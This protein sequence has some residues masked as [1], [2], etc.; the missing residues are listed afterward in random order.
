MNILIIN[1]PSLNLLGKREPEIYGTMSYG[2]L[3]KNL[4]TYCE[5]RHIDVDIKQTNL[6]GIMIDMLHYASHMGF[7][8]VV[9]NAAAFTHYSYAIYDAIKAIEVPVYEVHLSDPDTRDETFRHTSVIR[10]AC[11]ATFK[12]EGIMSYKKAIDAIVDKT[13]G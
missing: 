10:S 5:D 9:L 4:E 6:E 11:K 1:G 13:E 2:E 8:A 3:V 12:G 7:D